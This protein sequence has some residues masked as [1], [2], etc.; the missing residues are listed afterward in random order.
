MSLLSMFGLN[1]IPEDARGATLLIG[2]AD[3]LARAEP[4]RARLDER[5][6]RTRLAC[7]DSRARDQATT[8][9]P[10]AAWM[11][12]HSIGALTRTLRRAAPARLVLLGD[13]EAAAALAKAVTCPIFWVNTPA[14]AI[15]GV[16]GEDIVRMVADPELCGAAGSVHLTGDPLLGID[17]LPTP[18]TDHAICERFRDHRQGGRWI[19]YFA[20]TGAGEERLAYG[21][22]FKLT[23][24]KMGLLVLAPFDPARY[25][26]VYREAIK[27]HLPTN[28]HN[29][30]STSYVPIKSRVYYVEDP[31]TLE[32]MYR[33]ADFVVAGATLSAEAA[34]APDLLSPILAGA[35]VIIGP[36]RCDPV[37]AAAA[38]ANALVPADDEDELVEAAYRLIADEALRTEL[39]ARARAW[40]EAQVGAL[41]RVVALIAEAP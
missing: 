14:S 10:P 12:P 31:N 39:T 17:A 41:S 24:R 1:K 28:R 27:Y 36:E 23:R 32:A 29:R 4:L 22:F 8:T 20:A 18:A 13:I 25:E 33:C 21:T 16:T 34:H 38:R 2:D 19:G 7:L 37:V 40:A 9:Q 6:G 5:V 35:P 15:G 30:L 26:P 3:A 11:L